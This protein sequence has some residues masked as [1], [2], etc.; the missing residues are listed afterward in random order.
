MN[1]LRTIDFD[2]LP[3]EKQETLGLR[4]AARAVVFDDQKNVALLYVSKKGYY[5]IPGGGLEPGEDVMTALIRE[6][7]EECGC[8]VAIDGEVGM[9][10]EYRTKYN[11]KQESFCYLAHVV[12]PK[13]TPQFTEE[14]LADGFQILWVPLNEAIQ[15]AQD[16]NTEAYEGTFIVPRELVLLRE[17]ERIL[18]ST[19]LK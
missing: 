19:L 13:G 4:Q 17:A 3:P 12:G 1:L 18:A 8:T 15:L 9:T 11:V 6:C 14:E 5:K 10:I 7:L 2:V 16:A